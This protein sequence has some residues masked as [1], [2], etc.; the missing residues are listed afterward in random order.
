VFAE[1]VGELWLADIGIPAEVY[2]RVGIEIPLGM[3]GSRY[4]VGLQ[5]V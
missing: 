5:P 1:A 4:R 3:F 2:R